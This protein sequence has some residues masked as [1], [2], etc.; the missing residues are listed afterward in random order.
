MI[1]L[2]LMFCYLLVVMVE[3]VVDNVVES[4]PS[5]IESS[6]DLK[7]PIGWNFHWCETENWTFRWSEPYL[8]DSGVS[9]LCDNEVDTAPLFFH[10]IYMKLSL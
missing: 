7:L 3:N 6:V 9:K 8:V 1:F 10:R 4:T 2:F 5:N